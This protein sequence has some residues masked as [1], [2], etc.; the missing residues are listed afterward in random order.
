MLEAIERYLKP[1][2]VVV[3]K[4]NSAE[5]HLVGGYFIWIELPA[6]VNSSE[7]GRLS[8]N[9]QNLVVSPGITFG[10]TGDDD[11]GQFDH[12]L[13]LSFSYEDEENLVEGVVRLARV[14]WCLLQAAQTEGS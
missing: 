11:R 4:I 1:M 5:G 12:F 2:G 3:A 14:V 9:Q 13:R 7:V 6:G 10:V 8:A